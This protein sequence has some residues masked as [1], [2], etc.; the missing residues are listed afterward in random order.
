M[1]H[2]LTD[3]IGRWLAVLWVPH[4]LVFI[5]TFLLSFFF[6]ISGAHSSTGTK[7][8]CWAAREWINTARAVF[9]ST[10]LALIVWLTI[11]PTE[12]EGWLAM[13]GLHPLNLFIVFFLPSFFFTISGAHGTGTKAQRWAAMEWKERIVNIVW[14]VLYSFL[15]AL[16]VWLAMD[17]TEK[18]VQRVFKL[19]F[20]VLNIFLIPIFC[21]F[22]LANVSKITGST[23][24]SKAKK[25]LRGSIAIVSTHLGFAYVSAIGGIAWLFTFL[26]M[27]LA[28]PNRQWSIWHI[29]LTAIYTVV[30]VG[31]IVFALYDAKLLTSFK[32]YKNYILHYDPELW[33][34]TKKGALQSDTLIRW[35]RP[36]TINNW[37]SYFRI[38]LAIC[39][40]LAAIIP[41]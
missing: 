31:F 23:P 34:V 30:S 32:K 11:D 29:W 5:V 39:S 1:A 6:I 26:G 17:P 10:S 19:F 25:K 8:Q 4:V 13:V 38:T 20:A 36:D 21:I 35:V 7:A 24:S 15:L 28:N 9:Y 40:V 14:A 18:A 37:L 27:L 16:I 22:I 12:K 41:I 33:R 2:I 3:E